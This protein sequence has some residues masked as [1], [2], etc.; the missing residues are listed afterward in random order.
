MLDAIKASPSSILEQVK[1]ADIY[2]SPALGE[3]KKNVT[4]HF[5]YRDK[6]KTIEQE[7][8][9]MEHARLTES[10]LQLISGC[11]PAS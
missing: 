7:K 1:L 4:F 3:G 9:D 10:T 6:D 11:L 2:R 5:T 8:V